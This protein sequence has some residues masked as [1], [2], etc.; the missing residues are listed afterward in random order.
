MGSIL[1]SKTESALPSTA[2]SSADLMAE[3]NANRF[4]GSKASLK[5]KPYY[6]DVVRDLVS[7]QKFLESNTKQKAVPPH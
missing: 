2:A 3:A 5:E 4:P 6:D 7:G 1:S